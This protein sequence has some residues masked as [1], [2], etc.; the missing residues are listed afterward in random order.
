MYV[1]VGRQPSACSLVL[2]RYSHSLC[3][4]LAGY[5]AWRHKA[6]GS[7]FVQALHRMLEKFGRDGE[8]DFVRLLTRVNREV[9]QPRSRVRVRIV[10]SRW[11]HEP[12]EADSVHRFEAHQGHLPHAEEVEL[13]HASR[14]SA[15]CM[16]DFQPTTC[17]AKIGE[18]GACVFFCPTWTPRESAA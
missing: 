1:S 3:R 9:A 14:Q 17:G 4:L 13:L 12:Q 10:H 18:A 8:M 5:F 7:W 15:C 16:R 6:N 11:I 2:I